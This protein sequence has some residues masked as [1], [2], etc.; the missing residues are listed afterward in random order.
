MKGAFWRGKLFHF[1]AFFEEAE[2]IFFLIDPLGQCLDLFLVLLHILLGNEAQLEP[3]LKVAQF[4]FQF[5]QSVT[6]QVH[7]FSTFFLL[8]DAVFIPQAS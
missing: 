7:I 8:F 1:A 4:A 5:L 3:L 6:L 2:A